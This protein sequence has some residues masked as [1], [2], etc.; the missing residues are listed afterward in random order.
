MIISPRKSIDPDPLRQRTPA[1]FAA[2]H[3]L[4]WDAKP[5]RRQPDPVRPSHAIEVEYRRRL[6]RL[7][8]QMQRSVLYFVKAAYRANEPEVRQIAMDDSPARNLAVAVRR[9]ARRWQKRFDEAAKELA[10]YF[11]KSVADRSDLALRRTLERG[12]MSVKFKM[13]PAMNDVLQST[14]AAN[15]SLIKSIPQR[16]FTEIEGAVQRSVQT[17]RDLQQLSDDLQANFGVTKRR[18][19]LISRD[20]NNKATAN[21][22]RVRQQE[23]GITEA[24]WV[25]STAGK[26]PRPSHLKAG[27]DKV[28]FSLE[29]GWFDPDEGKYILPGELIS[30][31]CVSRP[32]IPGFS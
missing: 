18:A 3:G 15:V 6:D 7:V 30:C 17:G 10:A 21:L 19:A 13:T 23:L 12:G 2:A 24:I 32:V 4:A 16:Y 25:H 27:R 9:L 11:A 29:T 22:Q 31:R 20:Q 8:E 5:R 26:E 1:E 28:K 14:V